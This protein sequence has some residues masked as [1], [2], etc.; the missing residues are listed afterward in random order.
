MSRILAKCRRLTAARISFDLDLISTY[1]VLSNDSD[2]ARRPLQTYQQAP[3]SL[4]IPVE[5]GG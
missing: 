2:A 3:R 1:G 4:V 5:M